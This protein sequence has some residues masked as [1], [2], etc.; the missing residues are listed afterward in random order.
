MIIIDEYGNTTNLTGEIIK[1]SLI[2]QSFV[3]KA[4][5]LKSVYVNF[6]TYQRKNSA[7]VTL[8]ILNQD[9]NVVKNCV[10]NSSKFDD[11]SYQLFSLNCD[12]IKDDRYFLKLYS[13]NGELGKSITARWGYRKHF[14]EIFYLN[15]DS[16]RG[17]LACYFE[18]DDGVE[19]VV[20]KKKIQK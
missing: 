15:N 13:S 1:N 9:G 3:A 19:A 17:E 14:E 6:G 18:F 8:E 20:V 10:L 5:I 2:I 7:L 16:R 4:D 12:L 11:N